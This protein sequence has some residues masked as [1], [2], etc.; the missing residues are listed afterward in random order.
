MYADDM[1]VLIIDIDVGAL[2]N[3]VGQV[4]IELESRFQRIDLIVNVGK[5]W[6]CCCIVDN[7]SVR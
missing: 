3:K 1:Y 2:Q 4:N 5:H 6:L 7:K